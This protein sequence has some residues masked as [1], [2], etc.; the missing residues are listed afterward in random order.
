MGKQISSKK[1]IFKPEALYC[2]YQVT[3]GKK[4]HFLTGSAVLSAS[5]QFCSKNGIFRREAT[6]CRYQVTSG[7]KMTF[8]T[9]SDVLLVSDPFRS[10]SDIFKTGSHVSSVRR[11]FRMANEIFKP[12]VT[13]ARYD[14]I[15]DRIMRLFNPMLHVSWL[16]HWCPGFGYVWDITIF[17]L[18]RR[19][20]TGTSGSMTPSMSCITLSRSHCLCTAINLIRQPGITTLPFIFHAITSFMQSCEEN[21]PSKTC[22]HWVEIFAVELVLGSRSPSSPS[23]IGKIPLCLV[24]RQIDTANLRSR[25]IWETGDFKAAT[26]SL[27]SALRRWDWSRVECH[28]RKGYLFLLHS[29]RIP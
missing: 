8:S 9:G 10:E 19:S 25:D 15:S 5:G 14:I 26:I 13:Y 21:W 24:Q 11:H 3:S 4:W 28:P 16:W 6:Y 1:E 18:F 29:W 17:L 2:R 12:E 22:S 27:P 7:R 20:N 23:A